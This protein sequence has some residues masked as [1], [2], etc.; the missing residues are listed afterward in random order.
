M[1]HEVFDLPMPSPLATGQGDAV[2]IAEYLNKTVQVF[3]TFSA[4]VQIQGSMDGTNWVNI[5][6]G[7]TTPGHLVIDESLVWFR[8]DLTFTSGTPVAKVG[9]F[10]ART[11]V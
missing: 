2:R 4:T 8:V 1:R 6:A 3:G 11:D 9:A 7:I 5:G 10:N